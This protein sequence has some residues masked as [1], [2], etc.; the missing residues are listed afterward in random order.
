MR[1]WMWST[2]IWGGWRGQA[3]RSRGG[4]SWLQARIREGE[5]TMKKVYR[6]TIGRIAARFDWD[7]S[8][9]FLASLLLLG[10]SSAVVLAATSL[11]LDGYDLGRLAALLGAAVL[12]LYVPLAIWQGKMPFAVPTEYEKR[13]KYAQ[14]TL[15]VKIPRSGD[16][17]KG[18]LQ[19][20]S[21]QIHLEDDSDESIRIAVGRAYCLGDQDFEIFYN[22]PWVKDVKQKIL[23]ARSDL[24][25]PKA[26]FSAISSSRGLMDMP[27]EQT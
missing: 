24:I 18:G 11:V 8:G 27:Q 25:P 15:G 20:G 14:T 26:Y 19:L 5:R 9:V 12:A 22:Q 17:M 10:E 4:G 3:H 6:A 7:K 13:R 16:K 1:R 23:L 21:A 2:I